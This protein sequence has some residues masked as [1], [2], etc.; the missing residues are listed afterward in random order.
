M[1]KNGKK[2]NIIQLIVVV[3]CLG[4][5]GLAVYNCIIDTKQFFQASS[6]QII[7]CLTA[8]VI[9]FWAT[10]A[11]NDERK[12]KEHAEALVAEFKDIMSDFQMVNIDVENYDKRFYNMAIRSAQNKLYILKKYSEQM[13]FEEEYTYISEKLKDYNDLISDN[14]EKP[15]YLHDS[16]N[17]L[18]KYV[19]SAISKCD[20]LIY[21]IYE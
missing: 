3:F 19:S 10:Q 2:I 1:F 15:D 7:T 8:L 4:I 21:K 11:K 20:E 6:T 18:K 14:I 13:G 16:E 9:A 17:T 5:V 12:Q